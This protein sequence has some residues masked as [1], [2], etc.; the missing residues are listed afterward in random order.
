MQLNLRSYWAAATL[1]LA[2]TVDVA[3]MGIDPCWCYNKTADETLAMQPVFNISHLTIQY[4]KATDQT[5]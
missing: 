5:A 2:A 3:A 4:T 1:L